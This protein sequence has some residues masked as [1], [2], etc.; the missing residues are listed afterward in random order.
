M[1]FNPRSH[2]RNFHNQ[3]LS[4]TSLRKGTIHGTPGLAAD[5]PSQ[6]QQTESSTP[7]ADAQPQHDVSSYFSVPNSTTPRQRPSRTSLMPATNANR[8]NPPSTTPSFYQAHNQLNSSVFTPVR[9]SQRESFSNTEHG[10]SS[11][12]NRST[13][14]SNAIPQGPVLS[15]LVTVFGFHPSGTSAL[16]VFYSLG[17][18]IRKTTGSGNWYV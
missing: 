14:G 3:Q 8:A 5:H 18:V 2:L 15:R 16:S 4:R 6:A 7:S 13:V 11:D 10:A 1:S 17:E 12:L 9:P